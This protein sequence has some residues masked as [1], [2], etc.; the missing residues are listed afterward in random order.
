MSRGAGPAFWEFSLEVYARP[1]V[2]DA[3][4]RLQDRLGI[5]VNLLLFGCWAGIM[6]GRRLDEAEWARLI[7]ATAPWREDVVAPLRRVR[8][9]LRDISW[10]R[11]SPDAA[12]VLRSEVGRL[13][14]DAERILQQAVA[15]LC[16]VPLSA[17]APAHECVAAAIAN[18]DAYFGALGV[19]PAAGDRADMA[20]IV[21]AAGRDKM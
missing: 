19:L 14:L 21:E 20:L 8:R 16:P 3:C 5:D 1:G 4:L 15:T 11:V 6:G 12:S 18:V 10:S 13:E 9:R 17:V 7:A 2:A